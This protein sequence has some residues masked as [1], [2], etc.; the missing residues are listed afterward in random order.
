MKFVAAMGLALLGIPSMAW[1]VIQDC[2][3]CVIGLWDD[4][5]MT[6]PFGTITQY[7]S[8]PIYLGVKLQAALTN[9]AT[10]ELSISGTTRADAVLIN[11]WQCLTS[12][13]PTMIG[14]WLAPADSTRYGGITIAWSSCQPA[15]VALFRLTLQ[16]FGPAP[17]NRVLRV[18]H[19]YP[20]SNP[21]YG[22][23]G[24]VACACNPPMWDA[25]RVTGATYVLNPVV[26][27][28]GKEWGAVKELFR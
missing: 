20:P 16:W 28:G 23:G 19:K 9:F 2:P 17:V 24:P 4:E 7:A 10:I 22:L 3:A 25:Y 6:Q 14:D 1:A 21:L 11:S 15:T 27:V 8:K 26:S 18:T 5:A 12:P 13:Q